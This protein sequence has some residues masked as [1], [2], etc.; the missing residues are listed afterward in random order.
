MAARLAAQGLCPVAEDGRAGLGQAQRAADRLSGRL[1]LCRAQE[2]GGAEQPGR[3]RS[4]NPGH[5]SEAGHS[6]RR[7][8]NAR[9]GEGQPQ[10]RGGRRVRFGVGRNH[11]PQGAGGSGRHLPVD[12][13]SGA[14]IPRPG[15]GVAGQGRADARQLFR[16][17]ELR[18]LFRRHLRLHSQGRALPDGAVDLFPHQCGKYRPVRA[19]PDRR[20]RRRLC[21][22]PGRLHRADARR[23]SAPCRGGGTGRARRR[24]DQI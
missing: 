4:G 18:G 2:E 7:A 10:G 12:Q 22:L 13:R 6:D 23:E 9:R 19:H 17:I 21:F 11:L 16:D 15:E 24:R 5:L 20:G 14:R 8:G 1:L 3:G